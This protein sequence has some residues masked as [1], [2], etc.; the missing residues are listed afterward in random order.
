MKYIERVF[1]E[2]LTIKWIF[3]GS[4]LYIF[5]LSIKDSIVIRSIEYQVD[6][7]HWDFFIS[8]ISDPYLVI[9]FIF[10]IFIFLSSQVILRK[11]DYNLFIRFGNY[12]RWLIYIIGEISLILLAIVVIW[13]VI[14]LMLTIKLPYDTN[15]SE[16]ATLE[17]DSNKSLNILH[18]SGLKPIL[19]TLMQLGLFILSSFTISITLAIIFIIFKNKSIV[20]SCSIIFILGSIFSFKSFLGLEI[21]LIQNYLFLYQTYESFKSFLLSPMILLIV[22]TSCFIIV[23]CIDNYKK[24]QVKAAFYSISKYLIYGALC[25]LGIIS[26][27]LSSGVAIE[28]IWDNLYLKFFGVSKQGFKFSNYIF[29]CV[30]FLGFVYL[31]QLYLSSILTERLYYVI[32]R[33]KSIQVWFLKFIKNIIWKICT[34]LLLLFLVILISGLFSGQTLELK[35]TLVSSLAISQILYHFFINGFLQLLNYILIIFIISWIF[36]DVFHSLVAIGTMMLMMMP[37]VNIFQI[38]P[39]G[40]NSFGYING[41]FIEIFKISVTL[42]IYILIELK[43]IFYIFKKRDILL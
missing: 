10:P 37:S 36:K 22:I 7:N 8:Y 28:T 39:V 20:I 21:I 25:L 19:I 5:G 38:L 13:I 6:M 30:V 24:A 14:G 34:L 1:S 23:H 26:P 18:N 42:L 4:I 15:W 12:K 29:Y 2:L 35:I 40:L 33:Y 32:L 43:I 3:F 16:M 41:D 27:F 31:F 9:Y 11:W 17:I